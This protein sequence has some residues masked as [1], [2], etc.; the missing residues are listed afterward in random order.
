[1][2]VEQLSLLVSYRKPAEKQNSLAQNSH[3]GSG[4]NQEKKMQPEVKN[5]CGER[6]SICRF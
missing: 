3:H 4:P 2:Q 6:G 5:T 1:M